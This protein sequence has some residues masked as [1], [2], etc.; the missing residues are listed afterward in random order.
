MSQIP[1]E[2]LLG[3]RPWLAGVAG[4]AV[5]SILPRSLSAAEFPF[6]DDPARFAKS[7]DQFAAQDREQMP[8]R[9]GVLFVG[10]ST[11]RMWNVHAAFPSLPVI[12][13]GFGGSQ[14]SDVVHFC[15]RVI[16]PYAP[17]TIVLYEGDNDISVG[18]S[19]ERVAND[20]TALVKRIRDKL[21]TVQLVVLAIKPS[22][23]RWKHIETQRDANHRLAS[24]VAQDKLARFVDLGPTLLNEDGVPNEAYY[25]R[26]RL[27]LSFLGYHQWNAALRPVLAG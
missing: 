17:R 15:D 11:I 7:M 13:R 16:W 2:L 18:K 24:L 19:A 23:S 8:V 20:Y 5:S 4:A 21:P 10:S 22:P 25:I 3:R 9:N 26:D 1:S 6:K 12:N 14:M 27:H